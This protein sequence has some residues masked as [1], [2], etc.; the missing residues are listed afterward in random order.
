MLNLVFPLIEWNTRKRWGEL[1]TWLASGL[2]NMMHRGHTPVHS[3]AI[4]FLFIFAQG[5]GLEVSPVV[6]PNVF[7]H[8]FLIFFSL[9]IVQSHFWNVP[10]VFVEILS[11]SFLKNDNLEKLGNL[12]KNWSVVNDRV[13]AWILFWWL[14]G[15]I[16]FECSTEKPVP[17]RYYWKKSLQLWSKNTFIL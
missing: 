13:P 4:A 11:H 1:S 12:S 6:S 5:L 14:I 9:N 15:I 2:V 17:N 10:S 8:P 3:T 16:D 7:H